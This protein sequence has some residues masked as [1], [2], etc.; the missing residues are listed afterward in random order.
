[1]G[2]DRLVTN[3]IAFTAL[4]FV[5]AIYGVWA[6]RRDLRRGIASA[7]GF[8]FTKGIQPK[9]Y[10]SLMAFNILAVTLICIGAIIQIVRALS[11]S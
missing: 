8:A 1:V 2:Y 11:H 4:V 5:L 9:R 6:I 3:S 7:R 10:R